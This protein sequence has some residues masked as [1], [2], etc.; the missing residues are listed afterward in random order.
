M[1]LNLRPEIVAY[2]EFFCQCQC[3]V[4][5]GVFASSTRHASV[6]LKLY[7]VDV[8]PHELLRARRVSQHDRLEHA[9]VVVVGAAQ[10]MVIVPEHVAVG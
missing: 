2:G 3:G 4:A 8:F 1:A 7:G 9:V 6:A 10:P 5:Q